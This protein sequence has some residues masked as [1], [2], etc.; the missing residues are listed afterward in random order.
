MGTA[1]P[2]VSATSAIPK[3][4]LQKATAVREVQRLKECIETLEDKKENLKNSISKIECE[5]RKERTRIGESASTPRRRFAVLSVR[6]GRM[7]AGSE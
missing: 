1:R 2:P 3:T 4:G 5:E 6:T 7:Y